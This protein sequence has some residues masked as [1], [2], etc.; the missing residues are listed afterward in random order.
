MGVGSL[1]GHLAAGSFLLFHPDFPLGFPAA[2]E[3]V[4]LR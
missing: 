4:L 3:P 2:W 1:D